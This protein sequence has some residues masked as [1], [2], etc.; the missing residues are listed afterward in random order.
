MSKDKTASSS[1][2]FL[3]EM[4]QF[5]IY[6]SSQGRI[7]RQVTG[8]ALM[9]I[10]C[11]SGWSLHGMLIGNLSSGL[12]YGIPVALV[13]MGAWVSFRVV[14]IPKFADFLIAVEAE[15][16]K[17]SWPSRGELM[18]SSLVV[19]VV[20]LALALILLGFDALWTMLFKYVLKIT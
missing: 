19:I 18:R 20:I 7:A 13:F 12:Q 10:F 3:Q 6:K 4:F 14:N 17:V 11:L 9:V 15:M 1:G 5:G 8:L 2:M 16:K